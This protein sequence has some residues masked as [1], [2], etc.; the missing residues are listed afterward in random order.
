[1]ESLANLVDNEL[2]GVVESIYD[3]LDERGLTLSDY[4]S[5]G[6]VEHSDGSSFPPS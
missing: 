6:F 5:I 3:L 1:M 4:S 2:V